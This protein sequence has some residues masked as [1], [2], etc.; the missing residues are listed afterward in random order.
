MLK[1]ISTLLISFL[2]L[3]TPVYAADFNYTLTSSELTVSSSVTLTIDGTESGLTGRFNLTI[4]N[5]NIATL[6]K[7]SIWIE[8]NR[9]SVTITGKNPGTVTL[10]ILPAEGMSDGSA[11]EVTINPK[12]ITLTVKDKP[13][14]SDNPGTS[15]NQNVIPAKPKSNNNYLTDLSV[16]GLKLNSTFDKEIF[17]YTVTA[18]AKTEKIVINARVEDSKSKVEGTGEKT[19][20]TGINTFEII[21]T[22]EN[23]KIRKYT[24]KVDVL[25]L[26]PTIIKIKKNIQ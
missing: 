9:D 5:S 12:V 22:A 21:V 26:L 7:S 19:V 20:K 17:E 23:G 24:L 13:V 14:V 11:H 3:I 8:N 25:E 16:E 10:T 1:R 2:I 18:E 6:S 4:S 15:N